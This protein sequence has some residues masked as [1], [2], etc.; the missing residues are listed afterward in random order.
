MNKV[1]SHLGVAMGLT[2]LAG[3]MYFPDSPSKKSLR[4]K[5]VDV[6][7]EP[8]VRRNEKCPCGSGKKNKKCCATK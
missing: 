7:T 5:L 1:G 4:G 2:G 3:S 8:K 6:R